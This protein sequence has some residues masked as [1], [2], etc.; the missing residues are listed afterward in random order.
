MKVF[1]IGLALFLVISCGPDGGGSIDTPPTDGSRIELKQTVTA[2]STYSQVHIDSK[3]RPVI[4][5]GEAASDS[6][7]QRWAG[8]DTSC[9]IDM[10]PKMAFNYEVSE[11]ELIVNGLKSGELE[12]SSERSAT[13]TRV[14]SGSGLLGTWEHKESSSAYDDRGSFGIDLTQHLTFTDEILTIKLECL[15]WRE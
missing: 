13:L 12:S 3:D 9:F 7:F 14:G 4:H 8:I 10:E 11:N 1:G 2:S 15:F 5:T 6:K